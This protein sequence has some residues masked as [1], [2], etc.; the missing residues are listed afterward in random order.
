M[1]TKKDDETTTV[2][3]NLLILLL[4]FYAIMYIGEFMTLVHGQK[5][6]KNC[7]ICTDD[8]K[9]QCKVF[10][11]FLLCVCIY[12]LRSTL[13]MTRL[14]LS[15]ALASAGALNLY[16]SFNVGL[17][18]FWHYQCG[19]GEGSIALS[20]WLSQVFA[21]AGLLGD[22]PDQMFEGLRRICTIFSDGT[23]L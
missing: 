14:F 18:P 1:S 8:L 17:I 21:Q 10:S 7:K 23:L 4:I 19:L 2:L 15:V 22:H 5:G 11:N 13:N 6:E 9:I 16:D 3:R 20:M 12:I